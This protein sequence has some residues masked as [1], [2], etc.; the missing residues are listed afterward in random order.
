M[1]LS[2]S[3]SRSL[4]T[5]KSSLVVK[6]TTLVIFTISFDLILRNN[7]HSKFLPNVMFESRED[8]NIV[9]NRYHESSYDPIFK[10]FRKEIVYGILN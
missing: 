4:R 2:P 5:L 6:I 7:R 8:E 1:S 3:R 9:H 10:T